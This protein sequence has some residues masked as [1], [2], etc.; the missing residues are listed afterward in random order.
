LSDESTTRALLP[1][2]SS[3]EERLLETILPIVAEVALALVKNSSLRDVE[4]LERRLAKLPRPVEVRLPPV[5]EAKK[6]L[7]VEAVLL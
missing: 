5:A 4:P 6:R 7:E 1:T 2:L 3:E